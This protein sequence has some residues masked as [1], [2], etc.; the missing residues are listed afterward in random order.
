MKTPHEQYLERLVSRLDEIDEEPK[1]I[2]WIMKEGIW[3]R[4]NCEQIS[5]P[6]IIACYRNKD[7]LV[8]ELKGSR[9]KRE[10]ARY[11][12][13]CGV[14]FVELNLNFNR[15]F[16]KFVVYDQGSYYWERL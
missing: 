16:K 4:P 6:D 5:M 13:D 2:A 11:Q 7:F 8:A 3:F 1:N 10:K 15:I 12:I 9:K 14:R